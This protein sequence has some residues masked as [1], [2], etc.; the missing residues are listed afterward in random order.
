MAVSVPCTDVATS[1]LFNFQHPSV[2]GATP[3][4]V[5]LGREMLLMLLTARAPGAALDPGALRGE[6]RCRARTPSPE[7]VSWGAEQAAW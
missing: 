4:K 7:G 2:F 6:P 3:T 5:P 1:C